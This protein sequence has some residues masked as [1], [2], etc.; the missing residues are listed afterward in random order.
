M[1]AD[2]DVTTHLA[3][4]VRFDEHVLAHGSEQL[5]HDFPALGFLIV[6]E[7]IVGAGQTLGFSSFEFDFGMRILV[8]L[9]RHH[10]IPFDAALVSKVRSDVILRHECSFP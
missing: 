1:R 10:Q 6:T 9:A 3:A 8:P 5:L 4:E 2:G 7:C